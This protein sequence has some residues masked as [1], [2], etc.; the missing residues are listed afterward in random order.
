MSNTRTTTPNTRARLAL[1]AGLLSAAG[2]A[3][4]VDFEG[5]F[6]A[7]PGGTSNGESRACYALNGGTSGM[8][9]RLGNEC[10]IY[11]EFQ[12]SQGFKK[13]GID[14]KVVLM[15]DY[16]NPQTDSD[17]N[18][19]LRL[20][21]MF[22]EAKGFDFAPEATVWMGKERGRR[23]DV[24]IVDTY[25]TEMAGVG[26]GFKGLSA[27]PGK[28]GVA[29]YK[30][31]KESNQRPGH[32]GNF[33]YMDVATNEDGFLNVFGTVTKSQFSGGTNGWGLAFRHNQNKLFGTALNNVI[34]LQ[35]AQGSS[36]LNSNFGDQ[37]ATSAAKRFRVVE[38]VNFQT[39]AWGGQGLLIWANEK[40]NNG[41][42]TKSTSVGGRVSYAVTN[43]FKLL[44]DVGVSQYKPDGGQTASLTKITFAP[45]LSVG[46]A[47]M[48][49]PEFRLYVT[50][51]N[52]NRAAGN[53][54]NQPGFEDKTSGTSFGAQVEVWF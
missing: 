50:H 27:G 46:P 45:T 54:T 14:Y 29:Y 53:V 41:L 35:Y 49:R 37:T 3:Q 21:Q 12:L 25:F 7:G 17:D 18:K 2:A 1:A 33:E 39:G 4:A 47:L 20:T 8:K 28:L 42:A 10:D 38:S 31:D 23:G 15:T 32:R 16:Y 48:D 24:H 9:Y 13:N 34:W 36:G 11:G 40:D 5:Y 44:T 22:A 52:W 19:G 51:A 30:S 43:H 6:R 26:A